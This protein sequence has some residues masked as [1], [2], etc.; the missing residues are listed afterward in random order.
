MG[1]RVLLSA[2][3]ASVRFECI[4]VHNTTEAITTRNAQRIYWTM[5]SVDETDTKVSI[6]ITRELAHPQREWR[7]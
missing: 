1:H 5:V 7:V 4:P 6:Y 2:S 3:V